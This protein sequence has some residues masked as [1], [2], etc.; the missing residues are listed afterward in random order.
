[1]LAELAE[2]LRA[3]ATAAGLRGGVPDRRPPPPAAAELPGVELPPQTGVVEALREVKDDDEIDAIRRA[4]AVLEDVYA[5]LAAEGLVGR[6]EREVAW[7]VLELVPRGA[8]PRARR[9][10]RSSPPAE[11]ARCRTPSRAT[12]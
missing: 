5:A 9:S 10:T 4:A 11:P 12:W 7:R 8:A 2:A 6:T 3:P 1:M